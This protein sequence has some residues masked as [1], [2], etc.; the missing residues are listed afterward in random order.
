MSV[1]NLVNFFC[2][3]TSITVKPTYGDLID[4]YEEFEDCV[5]ATG[6]SISELLFS[7]FQCCYPSV[8]ISHP[9]QLYDTINQF[10]VPTRPLLIGPELGPE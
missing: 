3:R 5:K 2:L 4:L 8:G 7:K 6:D 1:D 9:K 10:V